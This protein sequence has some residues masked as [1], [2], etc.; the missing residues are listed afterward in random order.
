MGHSGEWAWQPRISRLFSTENPIKLS[1]CLARERETETES[2]P[3]F[4]HTSAVETDTVVHLPWP[5]MAAGFARLRGNVATFLLAQ[6][7]H[8][9]HCEV[10]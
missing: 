10:R 2:R 4:R 9:N 5:Q 8:I 1:V 3:N 6:A 7:W